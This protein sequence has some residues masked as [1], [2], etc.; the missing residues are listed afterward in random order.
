L[1]RACWTD[2]PNDDAWDERITDR[3]IRRVVPRFSDGEP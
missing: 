2:G 3:V 1:C